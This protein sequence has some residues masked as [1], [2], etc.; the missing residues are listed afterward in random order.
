MRDG[1]DGRSGSRRRG[2]DADPRTRARVGH[3]T[4]ALTLT[5]CLHE[6]SRHPEIQQRA[7]EEVLEVCGDG[8]VL[9]EHLAHLKYL[10]MVLKVRRCSIHFCGMDGFGWLVG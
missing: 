3:E 8:P 10:N 9:Y 5:N 7:R 2:K 6:L 4:T 1:R